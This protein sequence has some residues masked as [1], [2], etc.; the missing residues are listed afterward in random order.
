MLKIDIDDTWAKDINDLFK[1]QVKFYFEL[2]ELWP[3][4][5]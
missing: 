5:V 2:I 3:D 1:E 4:L